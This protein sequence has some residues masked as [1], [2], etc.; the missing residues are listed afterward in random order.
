MHSAPHEPPGAALVTGASR[1]IGRV[2]ATRLA[3]LGLPVV[4]NYRQAEDEARSAV[5]AIR[6][7]GGTALALQAD[8]SVPDEAA[9]LVARCEFEVGPLAV[10]I[11]N[12]GAT[13]DRLALQMSEADWDFTWTTNLAGARAV[14]GA[15][16][17]SMMQRGG[18]RI[19]NI[20]SVVGVTG[21]AGQANYAAAKSAILG[22]TRQLAVLCAPSNVT[23]NCVIPGYIVTDATSHLTDDQRARWLARIPMGRYATPDEVADIV[24]FLA[25]SRASYVTGQCIAVDGGLLAA[26]GAGLGS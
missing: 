21:N 4:V 12:A 8:L 7:S 5:N 24:L 17:R 3:A 2:V 22:F 18:G 11:N 13:R 14:G 25:G 26:A 1:G 10:V 9:A 23:V 19:V 16:A 15:A 20:A 6:A